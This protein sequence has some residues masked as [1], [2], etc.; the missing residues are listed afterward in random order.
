VSEN[1]APLDIALD[2]TG[3]FAT[4]FILNEVAFCV[5]QATIELPPLFT[6]TGLATKVQVG[7]GLFTVTILEQ[8]PVPP[9][10][11]TTPL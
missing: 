5:D 1:I 6:L 2:A 10:P 11:V 7:T 9:G 8:V 4:S 3:V